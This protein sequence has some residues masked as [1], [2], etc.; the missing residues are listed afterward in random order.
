MAHAVSAL[1]A[2]FDLVVDKVDGCGIP[3]FIGHPVSG[4]STALKAVLSVFGDAALISSNFDVLVISSPVNK[5]N[6]SFN[7]FSIITGDHVD[8]PIS[9]CCSVP[10]K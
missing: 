1:A 2:N 3:I 5:Y 4:E 10:G 6:S 9:S 7:H 8:Q